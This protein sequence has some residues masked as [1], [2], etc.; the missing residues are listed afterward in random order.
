M[1]RT[2]LAA[3]GVLHAWGLCI[4]GCGLGARPA[5]TP[6]E[7]PCFLL[8]TGGGCQ[9][10][11]G[12]CVGGLGSRLPAWRHL[13]VDRATGVR[14]LTGMVGWVLWLVMPSNQVCKA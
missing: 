5:V 4:P 1:L 9:L 8:G 7:A 10:D 6:F 13:A 12:G 14:G 2:S 3:A 11:H